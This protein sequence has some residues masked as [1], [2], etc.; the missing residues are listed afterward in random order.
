MDKLSIDLVMPNPDQPRKYFDDESLQEMAQSIRENGIIQPIIVEQT[1]SFFLIQDGER[2]YRAAQIAGLT[3]IPAIIAPSFNGDGSQK[4]LLRALVANIQRQDLSPIEEARAY[5]KLM[6]LGF[7]A[8]DVSKKTGKVTNLIYN[9]LKLLDLDI[10]IQ[11]LINTGKL[12]GD[13]RICRALLK[14]SDRQTRIKLAVKAVER[15]WSISTIESAASVIC[16][17]KGGEYSKGETPAMAVARKR[18]KRPTSQRKWDA[19][20]QIGVVP[21]WKAV[22][23]A[24]ETTCRDCVLLPEA[25]DQVCGNCPAPQMLI[26]MMEFAGSK[27][28]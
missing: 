15:G 22:V 6:D 26:S 23:D 25:S 19:L 13:G 17:D 5:K 21:P 2:R 10:E 12:S 24:A 1:D 28:P 27:K 20:A 11:E 8:K 9:K 3:E 16:K 18:T 14:I 4:R 7:S